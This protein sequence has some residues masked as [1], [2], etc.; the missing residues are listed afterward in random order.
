M[1]TVWFVI[2]LAWTPAGMST[3]DSGVFAAPTLAGCHTLS[4]RFAKK[5]ST[6]IQLC[7]QIPSKHY[8]IISMGAV[9][10]DHSG[11]EQ[12]EVE[13]YVDPEVVK[14]RKALV[15]IGKMHRGK[16]LDSQRV[17]AIIRKAM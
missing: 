1:T 14:L 11:T 8:A 7:K 4:L 16:T 2:L 9:Q 6:V 10:F 12:P 15:A 3:P 17:R 13:P 5:H